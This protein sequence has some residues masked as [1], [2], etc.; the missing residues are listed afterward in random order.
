MDNSGDQSGDNSDFHKS[1]PSP[2]YH[3]NIQQ[4]PLNRQAQWSNNDRKSEK[5]ACRWKMRYC[6]N[7]EPKIKLSDLSEMSNG[8]IGMFALFVIGVDLRARFNNNTYF[9]YKKL[10]KQKGFDISNQVVQE[11]LPVTPSLKV[12][13]NKFL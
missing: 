10:L 12:S 11:T 5:L 13:L 7:M 8:E 6:F 1:T 2:L 4:K 9:K 3:I